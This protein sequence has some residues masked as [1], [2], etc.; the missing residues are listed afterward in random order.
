MGL[1]A[2]N[3]NYLTLH[4]NCK[5]VESLGYNDCKFKTNGE[6]LIVRRFIES[7][8]LVFDVGANSGEWSAQV[9]DNTPDVR[10]YA[11][12]PIPDLISTINEKLK[13]YFIKI[14]NVAVF[15]SEKNIS[16]FYYKDRSTLSGI[17]SRP[18]VN[19]MLNSKPQKIN[20]KAITLDNFC[21]NRDIRHVDFL[22]IDTEGCEFAVLTGAKDLIRSGAID[23]IQ[24]EYGGAYNDSKVTL[25][26]VYQL[27][28]KNRYAIFRIFSKGLIYIPMWDDGLENFKLSNYLAISYSQLIS[29]SGFKDVLKT[30]K[31]FLPENPVIL[32]AG[33]FD[34]KDS[35]KMANFWPNG[36]VHSFEPISENYEKLV[37]N[38]N[39][40]KNV[41]TYAF[42]LGEK[43]GVFDF[44]VSSFKDNPDVP[45]AS[46]S[47]LE[48]T[49]HLISTSSVQFNKKIKIPMTT[50]DSW[51]KEN[52][53]DNIDFMWLD[54]QGY[55]LS[56]LN[57]SPEILK[58]VKAIHVELE[59]LELYKDQYLYQDVKKWLEANG[60]KMIAFNFACPW[61]GDG[62]FVRKM[63]GMSDE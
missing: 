45:T 29:M 4:M 11:F 28:T 26:Q 18:V 19:K 10:V 56:A 39:G 52:G 8:D 13:D 9:F 50:I 53:I 34:G 48:P 42:A 43:I 12:E 17:N 2:K 23:F 59:F 41:S 24:F 61:S 15:S 36:F 37:S 5:D 62:I 14:F 55:E 20:V 16:F 31:P 58:T 21:K 51:G 32:E 1:S 6:N 35:I 3:F 25:K 57:A 27:L 63:K 49:S 54:M 44:Y 40:L 60:F 38:V 30:V 46:S 33:A 22:K 7:N 47:I